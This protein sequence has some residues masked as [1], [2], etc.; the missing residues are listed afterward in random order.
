MPPT[1]SLGT[2]VSLSIML[3]INRQCMIALTSNFTA[4][5]EQRQGDGKFEYNLSYIVSSRQAWI[6]LFKKHSNQG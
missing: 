2:S 3:D 6:T 4:F 5:G 1:P